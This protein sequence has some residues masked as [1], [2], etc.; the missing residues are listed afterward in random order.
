M[1][2][3]YIINLQ[4]PRL[5]LYKQK[6]WKK[7]QNTVYWVRIKLAQKKGF[8]FYQA[9]SNAII[10]YDTL[11]ACCI[12]KAIL[13]ETGEIIYE[14]VYASPRPPPKISFKYNWMKELGSEVAGG[15]ENSQQTQPKTKHPIVRT[16]R[17]IFVRATIRFKCSGNQQT[18]LTWLRK[19][20]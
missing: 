20:Q 5:A 4:A 17:P 11:P 13:M 3:P 10:L 14:K 16:G 1:K 7:H 9:R 12:P 2:D 8:K 15:S 19:H 18:S 6:V